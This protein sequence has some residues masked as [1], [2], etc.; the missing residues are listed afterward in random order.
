MFFMV[1]IL[2]L[3][4]ITNHSVQVSCEMGSTLELSETLAA[5]LGITEEI[6]GLKTTAMLLDD[7]QMSKH[8]GDVVIPFSS[9]ASGQ[10][11]RLLKNS[12]GIEGF[13]SFNL[14]TSNFDSYLENYQVTSAKSEEL[15]S[16]GEESQSVSVREGALYIEA[17]IELMEKSEEFDPFQKNTL[18][19]FGIDNAEQENVLFRASFRVA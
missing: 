1:L 17:F 9:L 18:L 14:V 7:D 3:C 6:I 13:P 16:Q 11:R 5:S 8:H 15:S 4:S 12:E 19:R 2:A 10:L